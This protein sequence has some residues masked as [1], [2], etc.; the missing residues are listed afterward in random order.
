MT[1]PFRPISWAYIDLDDHAIIADGL[2]VGQL[3]GMHLD[4]VTVLARF[5]HAARRNS[6]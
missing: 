1:I 4:V 6:S 3:E 2:H 5:D